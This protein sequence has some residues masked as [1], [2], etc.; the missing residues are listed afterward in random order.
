MCNWPRTHLWCD[1]HFP[2]APHHYPIVR[3]FFDFNFYLLLFN[4]TACDGAFLV[5][6]SVDQL[7]SLHVLSLLNAIF[8]RQIPAYTVEY[9]IFLSY[10]IS[11]VETSNSWSDW[12]IYV[13]FG[14]MILLVVAG[15]IVQFRFTARNFHFGEK[16]EKKEDEYPLLVQDF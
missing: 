6:Y 16:K 2:H 14:G 5:A 7:A 1:C 12:R 9:A 3:Y 8:T 11:L 4:S 15:L 10:G 13:I